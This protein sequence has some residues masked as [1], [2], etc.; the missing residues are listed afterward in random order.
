M[1]LIAEMWAEV[2]VL[3]VEEGDLTLGKLSLPRTRRIM[4]REWFIVRR[5]VVC[6]RMISIGGVVIRVIMGVGGIGM[7]MR[8]RRR[9]GE[10]RVFMWGKPKNKMRHCGT[11]VEWGW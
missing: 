10:G 8:I 3:V 4:R 1:V 7:H 6:L 9:E 2:E 11:K 5:L